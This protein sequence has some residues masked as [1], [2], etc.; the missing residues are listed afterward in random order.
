MNKASLMAALI[1][2]GLS[3]NSLAAD[4]NIPLSMEFIAVNGQE[5]KSNFFSHKDEIELEKGKHT[6]ALVYKD[7]IEEPYGD[8]HQRVNSDPFLL[9]ITIDADGVYKLRPQTP[10]RDLKQAKAFAQ[11]PKVSVTHSDGHQ[12][13]YSIE[14]TSI[15][16][17]SIIDSLTKELTPEQKHK[18]EV[19]AATAPKGSAAA[20]ADTPTDANEVQLQG[21]AKLNPEA[22][23]KYWWQQ[24]DEQTRKEFMTWAISNM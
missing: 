9:H 18:Q 22:M 1:A 12:V 8:G 20:S 14:M 23:L 15:H 3:L 2:G 4:L 16:E 21:D 6:V 13:Q 10:I 17:E 7:L 5:V 11:A 19:I 24:A